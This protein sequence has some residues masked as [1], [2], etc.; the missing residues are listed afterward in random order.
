MPG[1]GFEA[2]SAHGCIVIGIL[3]NFYEGAG[4]CGL[5]VNNMYRF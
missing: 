2:L 5:L 3:F 1:K 4:G